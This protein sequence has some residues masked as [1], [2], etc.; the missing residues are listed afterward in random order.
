MAK[1]VKGVVLVLANGDS[2]RM[3]VKTTTE[4]YIRNLIKDLILPYPVRSWKVIE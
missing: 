2:I 3:D 1:R 4:R